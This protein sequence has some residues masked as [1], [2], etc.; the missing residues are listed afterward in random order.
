[1]IKIFLLTYIFETGDW[2]SQKNY[3]YL[4]LCKDPNSFQYISLVFPYILISKIRL[5]RQNFI[6]KKEISFAFIY[7]YINAPI[8]YNKSLS[9]QYM[10]KVGIKKINLL[11]LKIRRLMS[12]NKII[13]LNEF[14]ASLSNI[15]IEYYNDF[16]QNLS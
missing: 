14:K 2:V 4:A 11:I 15:G 8:L 1:M 9:L 10:S 7:N 3:V 13:T 12:N 6:E 5:S 16:K